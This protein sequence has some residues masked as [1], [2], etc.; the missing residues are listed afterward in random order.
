MTI[1]FNVLTDAS[2]RP[3]QNHVVTITLR[4]PGNPFTDLGSEVVQPR[5]QDTDHDGRWEADLI[6]NVQY[7][8]E[9]TWYHVEQRGN[10]PRGVIPAEEHAWDFVV[11]EF[12]GPY[13]LRD[14]LI[15]A[16]DPG[17]ALP[18]VP[19][20]ALGDHT[21]V[22]TTGETAGMVLKFNGSAWVP[23]PDN[24]G[25]GTGGGGFEMQQVIPANVV[26][27]PHGLGRRPGGVRLFSDDWLTE[28]D[29]FIVT[30]LDQNTLTVT[31]DQPFE[32]WVTAS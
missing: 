16:P 9:G 2:G 20:H 29:E 18:P 6:P 11:P 5:P 25:G 31:V 23:L 28:Y 32:G 27:V 15:L 24:S 1:V 3:L 8:R 26:T 13:P 12:G 30:H 10:L 14:V 7:E 19:P 22:D 17:G 4:A 21:D